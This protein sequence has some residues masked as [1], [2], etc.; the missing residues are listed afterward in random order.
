[1]ATR[2]TKSQLESELEELKE[3]HK[4]LRSR[5]QEALIKKDL[6]M[7]IVKTTTTFLDNPTVLSGT[8]PK[9]ADTEPLTRTND[10]Q[11]KSNERVND[12]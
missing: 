6:L 7:R 12:K 2:K 10:E 3:R 11:D 5:H 9:L 4:D 1:M 8:G